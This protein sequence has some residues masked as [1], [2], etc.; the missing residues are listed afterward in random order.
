MARFLDSLRRED[1]AAATVQGYRYDLR[2][3]LAWHQTEGG[4]VAALRLTELDLIAY[5]LSPGQLS[6][7]TCRSVQQSAS[8]TPIREGS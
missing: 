1:L 8:S 6:A 4:A 5:R 2:H 7:P 3:F